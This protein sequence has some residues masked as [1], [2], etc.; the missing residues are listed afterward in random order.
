MSLRHPLHAAAKGHPS[1][2]LLKNSYL[3][4]MLL[5]QLIVT[6]NG[7]IVYFHGH[8]G[9]YLEPSPGKA[10]L[11][12]FAM[13]RE[14]LRYSILSA[15]RT[16]SKERHEVTSGRVV[17]NGWGPNTGQIDNTADSKASQDD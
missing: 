4:G 13:A 16:A 15:L 10:N 17:K 5:R 7:D 2:R 3:S 12:V 1:A 9:K 8:T 11:N 14:G 6:A